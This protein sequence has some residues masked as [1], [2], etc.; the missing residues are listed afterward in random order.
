MKVEKVIINFYAVENGSRIK[1]QVFNDANIHSQVFES[2]REEGLLINNS[3]LIYR[4]KFSG[5]YSDIMTF[6]GHCVINN[7]IIPCT[8]SVFPY[9]KQE[10]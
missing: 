2:T 9:K 6:T 3:T 10:P 1:D 5:I 8:I 7:K 4:L